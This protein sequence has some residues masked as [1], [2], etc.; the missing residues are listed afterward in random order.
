MH[1]DGLATRW[2]LRKY[3]GIWNKHPSIIAALLHRDFGRGRDDVTVFVA[4]NA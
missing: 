2:D 3:P 4:R 1:S